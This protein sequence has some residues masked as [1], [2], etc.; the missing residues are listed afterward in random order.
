M[1]TRHTRPVLRSP[2]P[3]KTGRQ[4]RPPERRAPSPW[5]ARPPGSPAPRPPA[6][7]KSGPQTPGLR[8]APH[9]APWPS[10]RPSPSPPTPPGQARAPPGRR[11]H[12][13]GRVLLHLQGHGELSCGLLHRHLGPAK[14]LAGGAEARRAARRVVT[15]RGGARRCLHQSHPSPPRGGEWAP[16]GVRST[17]SSPAFLSFSQSEGSTAGR[18]LSLNVRRGGAASLHPSLTCCPSPST[19]FPARPRGWGGGS[20]S[21]EERGYGGD[22]ARVGAPGGSDPSLLIRT[23]PCSDPA[24]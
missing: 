20:G 10:P 5:G 11:P 18:G 23:P 16:R 12:L 19:G 4:P 22:W 7:G 8:P 21:R 13:E 6:P 2:A 15:S 14:T 9:A 17:Q 3:G 24:W 1:A